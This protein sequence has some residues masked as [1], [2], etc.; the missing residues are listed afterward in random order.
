MTEDWHEAALCAETDPEVFFP[1]KGQPPRVA[2]G[3]CARCEVRTDCLEDALRHNDIDYGIRGGLSPR[4]R[5]ALLRT[6]EAA[7]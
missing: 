3:I 2:R 5:R 4:E 7:A 6:Q 1:A